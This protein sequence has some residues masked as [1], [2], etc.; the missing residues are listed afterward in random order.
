MSALVAMLVLTAMF[1]FLAM[2]VL[3][4][5]ADAG[6][7]IAESNYQIASDALNEALSLSGL[8]RQG[9][10][11]TGKDSLLQVLWNLRSRQSA[12]FRS[13]PRDQ[14]TRDQLIEIELALAH[15]LNQRGK[16]EIAE[17]VLA[18]CLGLLNQ[19]A[20]AAPLDDRLRLSLMECYMTW[21]VVCSSG[22]RYDEALSCAYAACN[23]A[24]SLENEGKTA[25]RLSRVTAC[26]LAVGQILSKN[27]GRHKEAARWLEDNEQRLDALAQFAGTDPRFLG[28][29]SEWLWSSGNKKQAF[30]VIRRAVQM[31][32]GDTWLGE[33]FVEQGSV[34]R[35]IIPN[36][37]ERNVLL[38]LTRGV[39]RSVL[40]VA[41]ADAAND[42]GNV[43]LH[44][45]LVRLHCQLVSCHIELDEPDEAVSSFRRLVA[46]EKSLNP[47][48][49]FGAASGSEIWRLIA[50]TAVTVNGLRSE[51]LPSSYE[52]VVHSVLAEMSLEL[53]WDSELGRQ[54]ILV[55]AARAARN[56]RAGRLEIATRVVSEMMEYA[57]DLSIRYPNDHLI[58]LALSEV[59]VQVA[60]NG[61]RDKGGTK[62][63]IALR[64]ALAWA[65]SAAKLDPKKLDTQAIVLDRKRRLAEQIR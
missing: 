44:A 9:I 52:I 51:G 49:L 7:R 18:E 32:P 3:V 56:R 64:Q 41:E 42:P 27:L 45:R 59:H 25:D 54:V 50:M 11:K 55:V 60:K 26:F 1:G 53:N 19:S 46:I 40:A 39:L 20:Q 36:G 14:G 63:E 13:R 61:M 65:E 4:K 34:A 29:Q 8:M 21:S 12:L 35:T 24:R 31:F 58:H 37:A 47:R 16:D 5:R 43:N 17:T 15:R 33:K 57:V 28:F 6:R 23:A 2:A 10:A 62:P 22:R 30:D 38:E 48:R